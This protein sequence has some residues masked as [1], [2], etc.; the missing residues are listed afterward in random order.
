MPGKGVMNLKWAAHGRITTL[1]QD[2][3]EEVNELT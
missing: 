2:A 1:I 3:G